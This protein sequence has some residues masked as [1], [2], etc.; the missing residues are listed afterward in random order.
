MIC[1]TYPVENEFSDAREP[2]GG[3]PVLSERT[4]YVQMIDFEQ[5]ENIAKDKNCV[6]SLRVR[7]GDFVQRGLAL[8]DVKDAEP[9]DVEEAV[10]SAL[11][12]GPVRTPEQDPQFL[13]DE[14][15]EIGLRALSPGINDPFTAITVLHW[16]GAAT[17][18]IARRDLRKKINSQDPDKCPVIPR[19]DDFAHFVDRGFDNMRSAVA[20]SPTAAQIMFNALANA[21]N[22][23]SDTSRRNLLRRQGRLLIEQSRTELVG[24]DMDLIEDRYLEFERSFED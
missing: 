8:L 6:F 20:T 12:L 4:G 5:L 13:I 3:E 18:E 9:N 1:D 22:P 23:I 2:Q 16:L 24:P 14:L 19:P 21:A 7:I 11:T 10:R 17:S 15:V